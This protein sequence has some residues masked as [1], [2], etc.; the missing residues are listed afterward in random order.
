MSAL[1]NTEIVAVAAV[2]VLGVVI[3]AVML[4]TLRR[5]RRRRD[6]LLGELA[7]RPHLVQDR[8]FNRLSMARRESAIL[9]EQGTDVT[10]A[11]ELIAQSQAALDLRNFDRAYELAQQAHESLVSARRDARSP[12]PSSAPP[13]SS[14]PAGSGPPIGPAASAEPPAPAPPPSPSLAKNRA[15]SQF[16]LRLLDQEL[17]SA[18]TD[19]ARSASTQEASRIRSDAGA[20][21]DRGEFTEAFRLALRGRRTLGATIEGLPAGRPVEG[22]AALPNGAPA[23]LDLTQ[24]AEQVAGAERCPECGYPALPGD[25]FCRGCGVPR[26]SAN[27]PKCGARRTPSDTFC[28]RCGASLA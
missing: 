20:A 24:T 16:Q 7:D 9:S 8:A 17:A 5:L 6:R 21:F 26:A 4:Y 22:V 15:E 2:A 19:R 14:S 25:A 18:Q 28:G 1:T 23:T 11:G 12:L 10:R 13:K 3:I 27:C